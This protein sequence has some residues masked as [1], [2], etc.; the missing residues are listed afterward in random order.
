MAFLNIRDGNEKLLPVSH[1]PVNTMD[2]IVDTIPEVVDKVT[3]YLDNQ[4]A[5]KEAA[6]P[7]P[8]I[9]HSDFAE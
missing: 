6:Q 2:R 7:S 4:K 9:T 8:V 1:H 5:K 3:G